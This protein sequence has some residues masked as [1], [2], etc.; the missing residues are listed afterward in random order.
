MDSDMAMPIDE[1]FYR[2][3]LRLV[4]YW[5]N[6]DIYISSVAHAIH[7]ADLVSEDVVSVEVNVK[8]IHNHATIPWA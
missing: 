7:V 2:Y 8:V 1:I 3:I 5:Y 4:G 6:C